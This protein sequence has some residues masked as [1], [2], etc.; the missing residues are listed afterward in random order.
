MQN[1]LNDIALFIAVVKAK[2]FRKAAETLDMPTSTLS[3]R[4]SH[5]EKSIGIRLLY[6]TTRQV[7]LTELGL[8][9]FTRCQHIIELAQSAHEELTREAKSVSGLLRLSMVEEYAVDYIIPHLVE[10]RRIHPDIRFEIDINTRRANLVSDSVDIA[11]RMGQVSDSGLIAKKLSTFK[12]GLYASKAYIKRAPTLKIPSDLLAHQCLQL[13]NIDWTLTK[14]AQRV[15]HKLKA[16]SYAANSMNLLKHCVLQD[17]GVA[18]LSEAMM[19]E[20]LNHALV[21]RVLPDWNPPEIPVYA[22]TETKL[23]PAKTRLFLEFITDQLNRK[24]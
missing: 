17:M 8:G 21:V 10:F 5:L 1:N 19:R 18:M 7:E 3:R 13:S 15:V 11:F 23:L 20:P 2:S 16:T 24:N 6:R 12:L 22:L 14:N 9:Y 4:I